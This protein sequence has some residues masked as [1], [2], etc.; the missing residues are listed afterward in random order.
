M[1]LKLKRKAENNYRDSVKSTKLIGEK[2]SYPNKLRIYFL[3]GSF[4]DIWLTLDGDYS[5][6][7]ESTLQDGLIHRW[8]NASDYPE[9][10]TFPQ[11]FHEGTNKD[12]KESHLSEDPDDALV[13]IL[14]FIKA[15]LK[16][17]GF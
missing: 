10:A 14:D 15:R 16:R 9:V 4:L 3:N 1:Y 11:H 17:R 5:F 6:H 12:V 7:W 13:E 8:D 2:T